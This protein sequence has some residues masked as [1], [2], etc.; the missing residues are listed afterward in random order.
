MQGVTAGGLHSLR[1]KG[2][3]LG[4]LWMVLDQILQD[5]H[6]DLLQPRALGDL[7]GCVSVCDVELVA[8]ARG[9]RP[10]L[11]TSDVQPQI[12]QRRNL[13]KASTA[14]PDG[15]TSCN[16]TSLSRHRISL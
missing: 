8:L 15:I 11:G 5:G 14:E 10:D 7:L 4:A 3:S 13:R 2:Q 16:G 6:P 1:P 9:A 12:A